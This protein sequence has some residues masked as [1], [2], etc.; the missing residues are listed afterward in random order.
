ME[1]LL[2]NFQWIS[3]QINNFYKNVSWNPVFKES[4]DSKDIIKLK[5]IIKY[6]FKKYDS[7]N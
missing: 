6:N 5:G 4:F 1:K 3:K 7:K 2:K